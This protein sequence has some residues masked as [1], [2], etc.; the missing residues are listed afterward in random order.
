MRPLQPATL[1]SMLDLLVP[2]LSFSDLLRMRVVCRAIEE[3]LSQC[4]LKIT[5]GRSTVHL[6]KVSRFYIKKGR[7]V[8]QLGS[9]KRQRFAEGCLPRVPRL[10]GTIR[11]DELRL[12][13][14]DSDDETLGFY[15]EMAAKC[16]VDVLHLT[17][18]HGCAANAM[19]RIQNLIRAHASKQLQLV[20]QTT[21]NVD[22]VVLRTIE[23]PAIVY[24]HQT[25][26]IEIDLLLDLIAVGHTLEMVRCP[27]ISMELVRQITEMLSVS[28]TDQ[29]VSMDVPLAVFDAHFSQTHPL[30]DGG[31]WTFQGNDEWYMPALME[32]RVVIAN[33]DRES[34]AGV[35]YPHACPPEEPETIAGELKELGARLLFALKRYFGYR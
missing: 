7:M 23:H 1:E 25:M 19:P 21:D 15:E 33:C 10:F 9:A 5:G 30:G 18:G 35:V 4:A 13:V 14:Q 8:M 27:A 3:R 34:I 32:T 24:F 26:S 6:S 20:F 2:Y 17:I 22:L 29:L 16:D 31:D 28:T 12:V 11:A